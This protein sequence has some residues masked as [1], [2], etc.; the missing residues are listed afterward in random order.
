MASF[1]HWERLVIGGLVDAFCACGVGWSALDGFGH[2]EQGWGGII[3]Y[4]VSLACR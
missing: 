2:I 4:V 1:D 3:V